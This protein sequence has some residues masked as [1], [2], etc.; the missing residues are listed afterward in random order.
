MELLREIVSWACLIGGGFFCV[1][2]AIGLFRFP[3]FYTRIHAGGVTD[4]LG[5]TLL[6]VGLC[7]QSGASLNTGKMLLLIIFLWLASATT[8]HV[9]AKAARAAGLAPKLVEPAPP[10]HHSEAALHGAESEA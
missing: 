10:D 5:A 7:V 8:G 2:G 3:D 4:T 6:L 1:V 9:L